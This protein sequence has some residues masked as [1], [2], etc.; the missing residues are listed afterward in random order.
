M[1]LDMALTDNCLVKIMNSLIN[2]LHKFNSL[3]MSLRTLKLGAALKAYIITFNNNGLQ[4]MKI[5]KKHLQEA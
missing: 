1:K 3:L 5:L 4:K 2:H